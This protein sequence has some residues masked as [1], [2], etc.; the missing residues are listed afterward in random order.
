MTR[1]G[2]RGTLRPVGPSRLALVLCLA[3]ALRLVHLGAPILGIHSWRQADTASMARNFHENGYRFL[4]P[5]VDW[6][7]SGP[8]YVECEL[9]A[10]P[11]LVA[12][13]YAAFGPSEAW[14]RLLAALLSTL[15]VYLLYRLARDAHGDERAALAG[16]FVFAVLPLSVYY[17][18]AFMPE[19]AML[20]ASVAALH[21]FD[22]WTTTGSWRWFG[23]AATATAMACLLK[24][25]CLY[26]GLP[27]LYLAWRTWGPALV[28]RPALWLFLV[29]VLAP[30]TLWYAHAHA[31]YRE[32]GVT[33]GIWEYGSDKWGNWRLV[34]SGD[35]WNGVLLRSL[36]ERHLTWAGVPLVLA[37]L[38]LPRA[39]RR[40]GLVDWWL[41][42]L[43][44]YLVV[45]A[46]GNYVHE[47]YQLPL[48]PPLSIAMGRA[49]AAAFA[50]GERRLVRAGF[51]TA[52]LAAML[53]LG[54]S[55]L[56][57]YWHRED[58]ARSPLYRLAQEVARRTPPGARVVTL[59][60][61]NPTL[62]YLAHRKGWHASP[63][64][65]APEALVARAADGAGYV[66]GLRHD[67]QGSTATEA[68]AASGLGRDLLASDPD[69]F[70]L[71]LRPPRAGGTSGR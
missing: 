50:P 71:Q 18:R 53:V 47:Y 52:L 29:L 49:I 8:G 61:G 48:I 51:V 6:G 7:G 24:L 23:L 11:Y 35:F 3:L 28:R 45:V 14:G 31:L 39:G 44:V 59:D 46:R 40:G 15:T 19:A 60:Q 21:A 17:G 56:V 41:V 43:G 30:V 34:A 16:A 36:A 26:L 62:L 57:S 65:L 69:A 63:E 58:P 67:L 55:R 33:F 9:P 70:L 32:G 64:D 27:L 25:P 66:T 2:R 22:R 13:A 54:G 4:Y 12:L 37:G 1:P 42:A 38:F 5:Q 68:A 10:F 20:C